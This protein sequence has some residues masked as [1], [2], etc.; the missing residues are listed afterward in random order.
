MRVPFGLLWIGIPGNQS[1]NGNYAKEAVLG[2][3]S[4]KPGDTD[5]EYFTDYTPEQL[6]WAK[7][8]GEELYCVSQWRYCDENGSVRD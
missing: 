5:P 2:C 7:E 4:M 6:S 1:L 8:N 3:L